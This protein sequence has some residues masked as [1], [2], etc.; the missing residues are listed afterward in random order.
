[1]KRY[2]ITTLFVLMSI[3]CTLPGKSTLLKNPV[4]DE[5]T[6]ILL[7]EAAN[8]GT[9]TLY[10]IEK[11]RYELEF[12]TTRKIDP[13]E[14]GG[15]TALILVQLGNN[16]AIEYNAALT[17]DGHESTAKWTLAKESLDQSILAEKLTLT[18]SHNHINRQYL[19]IQKNPLDFFPDLDLCIPFNK[20]SKG[21]YETDLIAIIL[22]LLAIT[23]L[24]IDLISRWKSRIA[25]DFLEPEFQ[26]RFPEKFILYKKNRVDENIFVLPVMVLW[27][28]AW[29]SLSLGSASGFVLTM[30]CF[31]WNMV[32]IIRAT[33]ELH[34]GIFQVNFK[35]K[36]TRFVYGENNRLRSQALFKL[37][38]SII[39]LAVS[40]VFVFIF[41]T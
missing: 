1:L 39:L 35:R 22:G 32:M 4:T 41:L 34:T 21:T 14:P 7:F 3:A 12:K 26:E 24:I 31:Y 5:K 38:S 28:I 37:W 40:I 33:F 25:P 11:G 8:P 36:P 18:F 27:L 29:I 15:T 10:C 2:L 6:G 19:I 13:I 30:Y 23:P 9:L 16:Q 20:L 17:N